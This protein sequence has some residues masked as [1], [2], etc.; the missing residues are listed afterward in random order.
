MEKRRIKNV[1]VALTML[2][3][4]VMG[5]AMV[6]NSMEVHAEETATASLVLS[7]SKTKVNV[8]DEITVYVDLS[9]SSGV[10]YNGLRFSLTYLTDDL[11]LISYSNSST[12]AN[13]TLETGD[14]G[15][16]FDTSGEKIEYADL[17]WKYAYSES[18]CITQSGRLLTATFRVKNTNTDVRI[19]SLVASDD[20]G[21][22]PSVG[23]NSVKLECAHQSTK[24]VVGS[25]PSCTNPG[26]NDLVCEVCGQIITKWSSEIPATGHTLGEWTTT[27]EATCTE[28]GSK[29]STC[30]ICNDEF[31]EEIPAT[32]HT[33]GKWTV[34]KEA[35]CLEDGCKSQECSDCHVELD[36]ETIPA[37]G[38]SFGTWTVVKEATVDAEGI[39][40]RVCSGCGAEETRAIAKLDNATQEPSTETEEDD[41]A[42]EE[43][44]SAP[45]TGESATEASTSA[46]TTGE[47]TTQAASAGTTAATAT[48]NADSSVATGDNFNMIGILLTMCGALATLI[49]ISKRRRA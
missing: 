35:T 38:H 34:D 11:E 36:T 24:E 32:G 45:T 3:A 17:D 8:G 16:Y 40:K 19:R 2:I 22:M 25:E 23:S 29:K 10:S 43:S 15:Y 26:Y 39:E 37:T 44:T 33:P 14:T 9:M 48:N 5:N 13:A 20:E 49:I 41:P 18:E 21:K 42:T 47:G 1:I 31:T 6:F 28:A 27:K 4:L 46:P 12:Y 7:C 30:T